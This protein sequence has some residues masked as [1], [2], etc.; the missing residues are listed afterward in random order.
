MQK[1][2]KKNTPKS[3][4]D[5]LFGPDLLF[6]PPPVNSIKVQNIFPKK[7]RSLFFAYEWVKSL[8]M[9]Q[10]CIDRKKTRRSFFA[11]E[12]R[13]NRQARG[14]VKFCEGD[15][16]IVITSD[17]APATRHSTLPPFF[18]HKQSSCQCSVHCE[19][20]PFFFVFDFFFFTL[21]KI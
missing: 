20:V 5:L 2:K 11:S 7:K 16:C 6:A 19:Q 3:Q 12:R 15:I 17:T 14:R 21:K 9:T 8:H 4:P 13:H 18:L 10:K 1:K